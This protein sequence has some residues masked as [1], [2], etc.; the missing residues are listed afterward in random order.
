V[1]RS[2]TFLVVVVVM[3]WGSLASGDDAGT[4]WKAVKL[5]EAVAGRTLHGVFFLDAKQGWVV[6]EKGLCLNTGD[7]GT[8]W[9]SVDTNSGATLRF[10][11]FQDE[12]TGWLCGDGD[13]N[14]PKTGGHVILN[15]PLKAGTLLATTD[16]GK[17]WQTHWLPTN[18]DITC[19]ETAAAP[20]LQIGVSGGENHLDGDITRSPD[21]GKTWKSSR[22]YRS[23]FAIRA[24]EDKR[25]AAVGSPVSVGF[26]PTPQSELYTSKATRAIY[27]EDGGETWKVS[28][29]SDGKGSLRGLAVRKGK[30]LLAVGDRGTI[31]E[32]LTDVAWVGGLAVAVGNKGVILVGSDEGKT[33][34][35]VPTGL[36]VGL[37]R[38]AVAGE[39]VIVV[40]EKGTMLQA[41]IGKLK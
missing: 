25:W 6:G 27:S 36:M 2:T 8:T 40:G 17:T 10:V 16:G 3:G 32:N 21:G 5:P 41:E 38:V 14:A 31:S 35:A 1:F 22:C 24:G 37:H 7:G 26:F 19:V 9:Q 34:K 28:K 20:V 12:K 15:R 29:G 33:W 30:P 13:P 11:R 18:F 23:L 39:R 4:I